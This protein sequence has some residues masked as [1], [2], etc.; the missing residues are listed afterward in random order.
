M[1]LKSLFGLRLATDD[2]I[3]LSGIRVLKNSL[4]AVATLSPHVDGKLIQ[5]RTTFDGFR[6]DSDNR[7]KGDVEE[8]NKSSTSVRVRCLSQRHSSLHGFSTILES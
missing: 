8:S 3:F 7:P 1:D 6:Y 2:Y 4:L 5:M